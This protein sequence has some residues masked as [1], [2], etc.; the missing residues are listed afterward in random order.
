MALG[1]IQLAV[2]ETKAPPG[3]R[4][5]NV[6]NQPPYAEGFTQF[7]RINNRGDI[8]Y[9]WWRNPFDPSTVEIMLYSDGAAHR[10]TDNNLYDRVPHIND[11]GDIAWS[12]ATGP[13]GELEVWVLQD[14]EARR[15]SVADQRGF[16][17][18]AWTGGINN[19]SQVVWN[20]FEGGECSVTTGEIWLFDGETARRVTDAG[21]SNQAPALNNFGEIA[22]TRYDFCN[23]PWTSEIWLFSEGETRPISPV[24]HYSPQSAA[25]ADDSTVIWT[26]RT[27]L[28][29]GDRRIGMLRDGIARELLPWGHIPSISSGGVISVTRDPVD[30]HLNPFEQVW[31]SSGSGFQPVTG[32]PIHSYMGRVNDRGEI[33]WTSITD[34]F[35]TDFRVRA[36]VRLLAGD[37]NCDGAVSVADIYPFVTALVD[38]TRYAAEFYYCDRMLADMDD[39][40]AVTVNDIGAFVRVLTG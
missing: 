20:Q 32:D 27:A 35:A 5:V 23:S 31:V 19:A 16:V 3:Y 12:S 4:V 8:V 22:W 24:D 29:G 34:D 13:N 7:A 17:G 21:Q 6:G 37:L 38:P 26:Y 11:N 25:I 33:A 15:V 39:N 10:I 28:I 30:E 18:N 40:G 14:G 2:A 1:G 9:E 36:I